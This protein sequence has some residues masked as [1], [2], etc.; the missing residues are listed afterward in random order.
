VQWENEDIQIECS[1]A[2]WRSLSRKRYYGGTPRKR[3]KDALKKG[4]SADAQ[5]HH[6]STSSG[7]EHIN[8]P[9]LPE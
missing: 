8:F 7:L 1:R 5:A 6:F 3:N 2:C 4:S 9:A